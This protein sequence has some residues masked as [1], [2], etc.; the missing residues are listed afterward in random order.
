MPEMIAPRKSLLRALAG[1]NLS[2]PPIWLMRQAGRYLREYRGLRE[3]APDFLSF[4]LT[5]ELAAE[6]TLQPIRRF[7]FDAAIVFADILVVPHALG[8]QVG[9]R[10]GEGP[11]LAALSGAADVRAL[12]PDRVAERTAPVRET[13]KLV[14]M[15]LPA[16]VTLIG[17]AGSPWTVATYMVEG[18]PSRDFA[19]VK[20]WAFQDPM[21]FAHLIDCLVAA[22][23]TYLIGQIESGAEVIQLFDSWAGVLAE[24]EFQ[25]WVIEPT[26]RITRAVKRRH[27][28]VPIIGFPR[29]AGALYERYAIES[30]VDAVSLDPTIT[31]P[32]ARKRLQSRKP[33][34]G[35]LDP[36]VL[37]VGGAEMAE[38]ARAILAE[39]RGGPFVFNLGHGILPDTPPDNVAALIEIVRGTSLA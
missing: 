11:A 31:L 14:R 22:T 30:G 6:A 25:R 37:L 5:P 28:Q 38:A 2:V 3:K 24:P 39:L 29:G 12:T 7:G 36:E 35:N 19:R 8:Q 23:T 32:W 15:A 33:V 16:S 18:G 9:F 26:Q 1:E 17:F 21:G 4:C 13:L 27:P 34:Q 10:Q 20:H